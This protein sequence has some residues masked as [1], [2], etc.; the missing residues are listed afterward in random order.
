MM[1]KYYILSK[2]ATVESYQ[3]IFNNFG[4]IDTEIVS[5]VRAVNHVFVDNIISDKD[6][7]ILLIP[8]ILDPFNA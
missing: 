3:G 1:K 8:T 6:S 2:T 4:L 7:L 5:Y